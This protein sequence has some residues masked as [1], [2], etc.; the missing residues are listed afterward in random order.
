MLKVSACEV[1]GPVRQRL[2]VAIKGFRVWGVVQG[3]GLR[4]H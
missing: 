3:L 4:V 1:L 2:Y